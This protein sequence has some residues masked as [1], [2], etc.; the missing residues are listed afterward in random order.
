MVATAAPIVLHRPPASSA[1]GSQ[2]AELRLV[3]EQADQHAGE[4]GPAVQQMQGA[5][6]Q[7]C[8]EKSILAVTDV[9]EHRGEGQCDQRRL[10][11][12]KDRAQRRQIGRK[13]GCKPDR[14]TQA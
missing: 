10:R 11:P 2:D 7:R 13:A 4:P 8:G 1:T 5:A 3:G 14:K 6:E 9:D 12:R